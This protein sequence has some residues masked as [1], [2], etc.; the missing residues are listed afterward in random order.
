MQWFFFRKYPYLSHR[1]FF[2]Q[3]GIN[4]SSASYFPLQT[5]K[6]NTPPSWDFQWPSLGWVWIFPWKHTI[7]SHYHLVSHELYVWLCIIDVILY[8]HFRL[9]PGNK[10]RPFQYPDKVTAKKC[11]QKIQCKGSILLNIPVCRPH[12]QNGCS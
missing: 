6:V 3:F 1:I 11:I 5:L 10:A 2:L 12:E 7:W 4:S 8:F 9:C